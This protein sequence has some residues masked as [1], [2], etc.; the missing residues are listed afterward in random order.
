[1]C[2]QT[3][4]QHNIGCYVYQTLTQHNIG[5][6]VYRNPDPTQCRELCVSKPWPNTLSDFLCTHNA[7]LSVEVVLWFFLQWVEW[8][9]VVNWGLEGRVIVVAQDV[10]EVQ[11]S[12]SQSEL[13]L[14]RL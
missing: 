10:H 13:R 12:V 14:S 6:Y 3:L 1:M 2:T 5:R 9:V 7:K 8:R 11:V 4:T